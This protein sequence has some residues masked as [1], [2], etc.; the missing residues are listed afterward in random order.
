MVSA[1]EGLAGE[2]ELR[3]AQLLPSCSVREHVSRSKMPKCADQE[4][5]VSGLGRRGKERS[6]CR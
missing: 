4:D 3:L 2:R 6:S 1:M 5:A